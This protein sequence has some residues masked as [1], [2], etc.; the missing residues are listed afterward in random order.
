MRAAVLTAP[1]IPRFADF[2]EPQAREGE[3]VVAV[4]AA[5]LNP[6]DLILAKGLYG[7]PTLPSVTGREGVGRIEGRRIYFSAVRAP[8]GSMAEFSLA[9]P[10]GVLPVLDAIDDGTALAL[11]IAGL[12][13]WL[14]L[15]EA[16]R[17]QAGETVLVLGAGGAVGQVAVQAARRLGAGR[18]VAA[19]R[20][21][22]GRER[23]ERLGADAVVALEEGI[24]LVSAFRE[25]C[26]G[27]LDAV[28]D[29]IWG[30]SALAAL[31]ALSL[32]G[33]LIQLGSSADAQLPFNPAFMRGPRTSLIGFSSSSV[34][35]E[36]RARTFETLQSLVLGGDLAVESRTMPLLQIEEAWAAQGTSPGHKIVLVP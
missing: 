21:A 20:S 26:D 30:A 11:G 16:A 4:S 32:G 12:T 7:T 22:K 25:A 31:K 34:A 29:P 9:D 5:G 18:V 27:R 15:S 35:R 23:A 8:F 17:L 13:G 2:E 19:A 28:V 36:T 10:S 24:D 6:I 1:G 14:A 33:R 3:A